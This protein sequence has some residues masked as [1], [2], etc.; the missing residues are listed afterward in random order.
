MCDI[1]LAFTFYT[2]EF[3][4]PC[5]R[6]AIWPMPYQWTFPVTVEDM[7]LCPDNARQKIWPS[8]SDTMIN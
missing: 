1:K 7:T 5:V 2:S 3:C 4:N 6:H 8:L